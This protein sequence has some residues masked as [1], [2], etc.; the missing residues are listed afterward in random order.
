MKQPAN[1]A[2]TAPAED[3]S[4]DASEDTTCPDCGFVA[5]TAAGLAA[6]QRSHED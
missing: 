4:A 1:K 3:K 2:K 5:K 6:H